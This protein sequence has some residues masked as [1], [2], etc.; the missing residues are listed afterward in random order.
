M[1]N[2]IVVLFRFL[3]SIAAYW[4]NGHKPQLTLVWEESRSGQVMTAAKFR[5]AALMPQIQ[6]KLVRRFLDQYNLPYSEAAGTLGIGYLVLIGR[7]EASPDL[8]RQLRPTA[9]WTA[10]QLASGMLATLLVEG[11]I[12][13]DQYRAD[14][15]AAAE[16]DVKVRCFIHEAGI[17]VPRARSVWLDAA[18]LVL[19]G[20][21]TQSARELVL[22]KCYPTK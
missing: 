6:L 21:T 18:D 2:F 7:M 16:L 20:G 5:Q 10:G 14:A 12:T 15:P 22:R 11:A 17:P 19:A 1:Y 4:N 3:R 13:P 9:E 8:I